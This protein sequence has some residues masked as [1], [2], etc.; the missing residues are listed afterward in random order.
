MKKW[1][2]GLLIVGLA[3]ILVLS[4]SFIGK[5][6]SPRKQSSAYEF[7]N[8]HPPEEG[9]S[10]GDDSLSL[11]KKERLRV[12]QKKPQLI[13]LQGLSD[14][15]S[16]SENVTDE[17]S[18]ALLVW[19]KMRFL[20]T[21]S[22]ALPE[23][24]QGIKEA[25]AIWKD[26]LPMIEKDKALRLGDITAN[27]IEDCPYFVKASNNELEIPCGLLEDSS[28]TLIGI[29]NSEKDSFQ[30][31]LIGQRELKR[32]IVLQYKVF[33]PGE[34]LTKEPFTIQNTWTKESGW[35]MEERCPDHRMSGVL[36]V[37]G[38][39]KCNIQIGQRTA[40]ESL[41]ASH[42]TYRKFANVS[43]GTVSASTALHFVE[44]NPFTASLWVGAEGF[45]MTVNG[46]HE[47]S[48]AHRDN[49]EP[50]LVNR[51]SVNGGLTIM[52]LLAKGLP[53][54][55]DVDLADAQNLR[56]PSLSNKRLA[57]LIGV[58][59]AG[60]NFERRMAIRRTWMKYDSIQ[61]GDV[62]VRF[63]IG[64]HVN[65]EV[66]FK[67][68][69]EAQAYKDIQLMPFVD[70]YSLLTYKTIA[71]CILGT[72]ISSAKFIMKTD[73]DAFVRINEVLSSLKEKPSNGLLYGSIS[74]D[75]EPHRDK[76]NKWYIS[77]KEWPHSLYPPWA[78]GPGY[79]ISQDI[80]KFIVYGH[81]K[82]ELTLFK[83]EDVGVGIW[84]EQFEKH[85]HKIEYV[86][87]DRFH[88]AG[89]ESDYILAHY[90]NPRKMLCLWEKLHKDQKPECCED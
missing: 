17:E 27:E 55:E 68:W 34:N 86:N 52:S 47:T 39:I 32:P 24:A 50:W 6:E 83:L 29:P 9:N 75:S 5:P 81:M 36:R 23:T 57:L 22:D 76:D 2:G 8:P 30:I 25:L 14:L 67:L 62:A 16:L 53:V 18:D 46:R 49:L 71:I 3:F 15:Y 78:H 74:F 44:G 79:I 80:A 72:K 10:D 65:K 54:T 63:F 60:I 26:L 87:D 73:D 43:G 20:F 38:L 88:N 51:V 58:F 41:N 28:I 45:H 7:F 12:V 69:K 37:D 77:D 84:V 61:S 59:S 85:G 31:E 35:G 90:Q 64:L 4:Y 56:A 89:C 1:T 66:N 33:L 19:R 21:R 48:F 40:E 13:H 82:R 70:Y 11:A 42:P